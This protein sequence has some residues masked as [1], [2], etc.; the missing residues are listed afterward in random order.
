MLAELGVQ[1]TPV[2]HVFNKLDLLGREEAEAL[3]A[4]MDNL[5]P[6][7]VFVS[8]VKQAGLESLRVA[9]LEARRAS[10]PVTELRLSAS[11]GRR[12]AELHR[13]AEVLSQLVDEE[14]GELVLR[15]RIHADTLARLGF[16]DQHV[17]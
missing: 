11:D 14:S 15:V 17:K 9:L 13:G 3:Q 16:T 5:L 12:L 6:G 1:G 8:A 2:V 10:R 4:R 7:S